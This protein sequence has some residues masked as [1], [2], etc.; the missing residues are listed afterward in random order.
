MGHRGT[1]TAEAEAVDPMS[2]LIKLMETYFDNVDA[3]LTKVEAIE[4]K[5][6]TL[7]VL[8]TNLAAENRN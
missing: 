1:Q 4:A 3:K 2:D 7:E 8:L 5:V 6:N